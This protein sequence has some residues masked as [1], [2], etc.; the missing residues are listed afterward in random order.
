MGTVQT[1]PL[2]LP[3]I[4]FARCKM[5]EIKFEIW[6]VS[7]EELLLE[8]TLLSTANGYIGMRAN[9]EEGYPPEY[10]TMRGTYINGFYDEH[11]VVS[12]EQSYGEKN[13]MQTLVNVIDVQGIKVWIDDEAFTLF[14]GTVLKFERSID[15]EQGVALRK[16]LWQ[17]PQGKQLLIEIKRMSSFEKVELVT[18]DY[19]VKAINFTGEVTIVSEVNGNVE[20]CTSLDLLGT[21]TEGTQHLVVTELKVEEDVTIMQAKTKGSNLSMSVAVAHSLTMT[22]VIEGTH[23]YSTYKGT[24]RKGKS[25]R[26]NKYIIFTDSRRHGHSS[27]IAGIFVREAMEHGIDQWYRAQKDYLNGFWRY[28]KVDIHGNDGLESKVNFNIYQLL[29]SAG[30]DGYS[31]IPA[32]GITGEGCSGHYFWDTDI[33]MLPLFTLTQPGMARELLMYR[34]KTLQAS[35]RRAEA[36]GH[37]MGA[38]ISWRTIDGNT[39]SVNQLD[40]IAQYHINGAVAYSFSHYWH[41]TGDIEFMLRYGAEVIIET[42]RIWLDL[43]N[44]DHEGR[45]VINGVTGPDAYST[46]VNNNYYTNAIAKW[47]LMEVGKLLSAL[48]AYDSDQYDGLIKRLKLSHREI[49]GMVHAATTM[50]LPYSEVLGVD[51]QDDSFQQKA[52]WDFVNTPS[53]SFPLADYYHPL[54]LYRHKVL[55]QADTILAHLLL[56]NRNI[57]IMLKTYDYYEPY[58]THD[59]S[60]SYCV[61]GMM[62]SRVGKGDKALEYLMKTI[63]LDFEACQFATKNGMHMGNAGGVYMSIVYGYG[64]FRMHG[65]DV[66]IRPTVPLGWTGYGFT[67]IYRGCAAKVTVTNATISIKAEQAF[68][69]VVY[70][71]AYLVNRS[72]TI[73]IKS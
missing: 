8:E 11:P 54:T 46:V 72:L 36:L 53:T 61:Y 64:G 40:D 56:D 71:E 23:V 17:S 20:N 6:P 14:E 51:L 52:P 39:C 10:Q 60:L 47:H 13:V 29:S 15:M 57:E 63:N 2:I 19:K 9:F 66:H 24:L 35:K 43:G 1:V 26:L 28:S 5:N 41:I 37:A 27:A 58:T 3:K 68:P 49:K 59:S 69:I 70:D 30:R 48:E 38:K 4:R 31:S 16:I 21:A 45:F 50:Y 22:H 7:V 33:Y 12:E 62:A 34:Y 65:E 42:A 44:Y 32:R 73:P 18:I 25:V 67:I 55:K